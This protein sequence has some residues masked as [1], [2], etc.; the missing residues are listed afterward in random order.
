MRVGAGAEQQVVLAHVFQ[1]G[2]DHFRAVVRVVDFDA[3]KG[4]FGAHLVEQGIE[5]LAQDGVRV[6]MLTGDSRTT[7]QAVARKDQE[8]VALRDPKV[9][10]FNVEELLDQRILTRVVQ[11]G[12]VD[13]LERKYKI[14]P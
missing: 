13:D 4:N 6:V 12:Y 10:K 7:A 11:S 2:L 9:M 5:L 3:V 1:V 8:I 14:R